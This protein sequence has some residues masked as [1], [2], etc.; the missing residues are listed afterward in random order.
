MKKRKLLRQKK[1][2]ASRHK[3]IPG[4]QSEQ[5]KR[6]LSSAAYS[7]RSNQPESV[8]GWCR[9]VLA[10]DPENSDAYNLWGLSSASIGRTSLALELI[11]HALNIYPDSPVYN[12][13]MG[14]VSVQMGQ[15][16][17]ALRYFETALSND[18]DNIEVMYNLIELYEKTN[19]LEKMRKCTEKTLQLKP[20]SYSLRYQLAKLEYRE[21]NYNVSCE[22]ISNLLENDLQH[23][24]TQ[25]SYHLLAQGCD[26][27]G[28]YEEAYKAFDTS[29]NLLAASS[30]VQSQESKRLEYLQ[31]IDKLRNNA[32]LSL[33]PESLHKLLENSTPTPIFLVGFPRSGTTLTGQLL[34]A[35]SAFYT[36]DEQETLAH[37]VRDFFSLEKYDSLSHL[38]VDA[39]K[40]YRAKYSAILHDLAGDQIADG[41]RIVD[42]SPLYICYLEMI[43]LFFPESKIIVIHRDPRDVCISNFMQDFIPTP[44]MNN[45]LS[46]E[47]SVTFYEKIMGLFLQNREK[48]TLSLIELRYEDLVEDT[49]KAFT[50]T[51]SFLG[52]DWEEDINNYYRKSRS[53]H[54]RTPSYQQVTQ[55]I[56]RSSLGRWKNYHDQLAPFLVRLQ[57][58]VDALGYD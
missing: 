45:F 40:N 42:K 5:I 41:I 9:Q 54:I 43:Q 8:E 50:R 37:I 26:C 6:M 22:I 14:I 4:K 53:I 25:K 27:L 2:S 17:E 34:N 33:L 18:S 52:E 58:F 23:D 19:Q 20:N 3:K 11:G 21:G 32:S 13:N 24:L 29:N 57:V 31:L 39:L 7:F 35:H 1:T 30:F 28:K 15:P 46:L 55:P 44:F 10:L 56:Y 16:I 49:K 48:L 38:Q 12:C 36:L 47:K 51:L